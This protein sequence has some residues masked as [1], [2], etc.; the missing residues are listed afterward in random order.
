MLVLPMLFGEFGRVCN[1]FGN[2]KG[3]ALRVLCPRIGEDPTSP[4]CLAD[5][6]GADGED[7]EEEEEERGREG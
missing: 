4:A 5:G 2:C 1:I 6:D 3:A 7:E